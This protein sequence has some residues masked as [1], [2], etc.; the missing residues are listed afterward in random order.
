M[1]VYIAALYL[2]DILVVKYDLRRNPNS[3]EIGQVGRRGHIKQNPCIVV[4]KFFF[5]ILT[6]R[7]VVDPIKEGHAGKGGDVACK[8]GRQARCSIPCWGTNILGNRK[9]D[10]VYLLLSS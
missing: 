5:I 9:V 7:G 6:L 10:F 4:S 3:N 1:G 8:G 2:S